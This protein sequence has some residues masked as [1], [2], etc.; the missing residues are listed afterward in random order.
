VKDAGA[1]AIFG[2]P[3]AGLDD[4]AKFARAA[5]GCLRRFLLTSSILP[6]GEL[7]AF[8]DEQ[9]GICRQRLCIGLL[10]EAPHQSSPFSLCGR[11]QL[12]LEVRSQQ[13]SFAQL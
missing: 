7:L 4:D 9:L 13:V 11:L 8:A 5:G 3:E 6:A 12:Q 1:V 2:Q 10:S